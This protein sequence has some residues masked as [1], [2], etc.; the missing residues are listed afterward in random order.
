VSQKC[1]RS[2]LYCHAPEASCMMG[3]MQ[4]E[5]CPEWER[6]SG[7]P[8]DPI[9]ASSDVLVLPWNGSTLGT[10]DRPFVAGRIPARTVA[11]IGPAEAG[12]TTLLAACYLVLGRGL[13]PEGYQFAG[14]YTL[15][16]WENIAHALRWNSS[17]P[18]FPRHTSSGAG[19]VPGLL[20][21]AFRN[22]ATGLLEDLFFVDAPG[23]WFRSWAVDRDSGEAA[24]ARWIAD[25]ADAFL[26]MADS[27]ALA[28][29]ERG[30]A[31]NVLAQILQRVGSE[32]DGRRVALIWA[33]S[34]VA[35]SEGMKSAVETAAT[36]HLGAHD[37][38][39][40]SIKNDPDE[41]E[42]AGRFGRLLEWMLTPDPGAYRPHSDPGVRPSDHFLGLA[43]GE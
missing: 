33:K 36:K 40:W 42:A 16:G 8:S 17:A 12:K 9:V 14:S 7:E 4:Y 31:R 24:G 34:D 13:S 20:H 23:E 3:H 30:S 37:V 11:V 15:T 1:K 27:S 10:T 32:I 41:G 43:H 25:H 21:L 39:A 5:A 22:S 35:V 38:M 18:S 29:P 26:V 6:A 19:R 28:G 2:D